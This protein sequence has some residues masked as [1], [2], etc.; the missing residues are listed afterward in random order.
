MSYE[1]LLA[2]ATALKSGRDRQDIL[3]Y[4][5]HLTEADAQ[6]ALDDLTSLLSV[7]SLLSRSGNVLNLLAEGEEN[8]EIALQLSVSEN[9]VKWHV[10]NILEKLYAENRM[11]AVLAAKEEGFI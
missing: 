3:G 8:K 5:D 11:K 7:N 10:R 2:L 9:T 6:A 4:L 1:N